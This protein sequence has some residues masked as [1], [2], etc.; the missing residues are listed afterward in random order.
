MP[1]SK[2]LRLIIAGGGTGGHVLPAVA[3]LQELE[4]R[5]QVIE[6]LWI[7]SEGGI[8]G[9]RAAE[10]GIPF[11]TIP[12]GK[13][14]RYLDLKT[15]RDATNVP[16][17]YWQARAIVRQF[18][19]DVT[20]S[21]GGYVSVPTV[22]AARGSGP[23]LTHEQ[24][25]ILGMATRINVHS[26]D[27]LALSFDTTQALVKHR[28]C[29]TVVT[30]NPVRTALF[31]GNRDTGFAR[32]GLDPR[33]PV[34]LIMGGALGAKPINDRVQ[35]MLAGLLTD[36]QVIHQ[37]GPDSANGDFSRLQ[38]Y[39][40]T[41]PDQLRSRYVVTEFIGP[42][43]ADTYAMADLMICR[44]GAGTVSEIA[45]LGKAA[46]LIPLPLSGGGEQVTNAR[47]LAGKDAARVIPQEQA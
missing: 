18:R 26:A 8:E 38:H 35:S 31:D 22:A 13:L 29:R 39:R 9:Q 27:V 47:V 7:G 17:G 12:T 45:A 25:T 36:A 37:T 15:A 6:A 42:E 44:A 14:R 24:T 16:R 11:N 5:G 32:Y 34:V 43:I 23:I 10:L 40:M 33:E 19:P 28:R 4:A 1:S 41:L 21:T 30:G 46:I 2:S 3:V 20:L